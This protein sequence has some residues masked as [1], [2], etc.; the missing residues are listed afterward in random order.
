MY[1]SKANI[2]LGHRDSVCHEELYIEAWD[3]WKLWMSFDSTT[4]T[5]K[6]N[7]ELGHRD[8]ALYVLKDCS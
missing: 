7:I 6:V 5:R 1:T 3:V 2:E 8:S 4:C